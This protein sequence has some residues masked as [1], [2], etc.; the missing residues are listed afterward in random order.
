M[1]DAETYAVVLTDY[2]GDANAT[3]FEDKVL[4]DW[5]NQPTT[6]PPG[7]SSVAV[8]IPEGYRL[9]DGETTAHITVGSPDNDRW[10]YAAM[11]EYADGRKVTRSL[12]VW[13]PVQVAKELISL[14]VKDENTIEGMDY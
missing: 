2:D 3:V 12:D 14:G 10:L 1:S 4:W 6:F 13:Q 11:F 7:V 9:E 5:L 8:P